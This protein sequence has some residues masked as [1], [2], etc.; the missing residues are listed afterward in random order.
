MYHHATV[1]VLLSRSWRVR[2]RAQ[3]SVK[4]LLSSLGGSSLAHG[5][6]GELQVVINKHKVQALDLKNIKPHLLIMWNC[7]FACLVDILLPWTVAK[8]FCMLSGFAPGRPVVRVRR[9]GWAGPQLRSSTCPAGCSVCH[10]LHCQPMGWLQWSR[11]L[12]HGNPHSHSSSIH[13]YENESAAYLFTKMTPFLPT[14]GFCSF[15]KTGIVYRCSL[16][17]FTSRQ[18][19]V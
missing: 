16:P 17:C 18:L 2:K 1:V 7:T 10:L 12:G 9:A 14:P 8:C 4:K 15:N 3:Q 19:C 13:R 11:E 5:L 6:L